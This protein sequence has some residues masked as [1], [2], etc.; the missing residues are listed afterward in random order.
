MRW[1]TKSGRFGDNEIEEIEKYVQEKRISKHRL[2]RLAV[3]DVVTNNRSVNTWL[4]KGEGFKKVL[5]TKFTEDEIEKIQQYLQK[6]GLTMNDLIRGSIF[7]YINNVNTALQ[8]YKMPESGEVIKVLRE[9]VKKY[10]DADNDFV[11]M[12]LC[13]WF[14]IFAEPENIQI[15]ASLFR[16]VEKNRIS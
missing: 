3:L 10:V 4:R 8:S 14:N 2:V 15:F 5:A 7:Y 9:I 11:T 16:A 12:R 6:R 1:I 13:E